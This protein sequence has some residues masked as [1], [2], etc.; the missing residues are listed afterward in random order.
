M[1]DERRQIGTLRAIGL[2]ID[3]ILSVYLKKYRMIAGIGSLLGLFLALIGGNVFFRQSADL[4]GKAEMTIL[5]A[6]GIPLLGAVVV[7]VT[8]VISARRILKKDMTLSI[9]ELLTRTNSETKRNKRFLIITSA[10][11]VIL[12]VIPL[13]LYLAVSDSS[14]STYMGAAS[15]D[16]T[17]RLATDDGFIS[18]NDRVLE[19]LQS[20]KEIESYDSFIEYKGQVLKEDQSLSG[21]QVSVGDF[22]KTGLSYLSGQSPNKDG[23]IALSLLNSELLSKTTGDQLVISL[24][25]EAVVLR[26]SG[27]YQDVTN[28]GYTAKMAVNPGF[29]QVIASDYLVTL[30]DKENT[31]IENVIQQ[32]EEKT[33]SGTKIMSTEE[34]ISKTM[35]SLVNSLKLASATIWITTLLLVGLLTM[36]YVKYRILREKDGIAVKK[37]IGFSAKAVIR[38]YQFKIMGIIC[39]AV[40]IATV[41]SNLL[42]DKVVS[43]LLRLS[44]IGIVEISFTDFNLLTWGLLPVSILLISFLVVAVMLAEIKRFKIVEMNSF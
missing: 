14:F 37:A 6:I 38:E 43:L 41:F 4:L 10:A 22:E 19:A 7:Y 36:L 40:L 28:G 12:T 24:N 44:N 27:V 1:E 23:E 18:K 29:D 39:G 13:N 16:L 25:G 26:V 30:K 3:D 5:E 11:A 42:G 35:S 33:A 32:L 8:I 9:L 17:I 31:K 21:I 15:S 20:I 2:S 34:Y